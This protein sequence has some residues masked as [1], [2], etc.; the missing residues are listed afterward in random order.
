MGEYESSADWQWRVERATG[1]LR[2]GGSVLFL[3]TAGPDQSTEMLTTVAAHTDT[4]RTLR[5]GA[6][7]T[8]ATTSYAALADLLAT[9]TDA[10]LAPL[11]EPQRAVLSGAPFGPERQ[12]DYFTPAAV[13]VAVLNLLRRFAR[14]GP[15]LLVLDQLHHLDQ[16]SADVLRFVARAAAGLPISVL[17]TEH[18]TGAAHRPGHRMC[19]R[20]LLVL[21]L[22]TLTP[23]DMSNLIDA[24]TV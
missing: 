24:L 9:V 16:A 23:A 10:D 14:T 7:P 17:A 13:R 18:L 1:W 4:Y 19:P 6:D 11:P 5:C 2:D 12:A 20:P 3:G 22:G 21:G 15:V 8:R